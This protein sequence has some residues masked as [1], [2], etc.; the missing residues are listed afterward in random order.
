MT[1]IKSPNKKHLN[2]KVNCSVSFLAIVIFC[3]VF[4]SP[5]AFAGPAQ[6]QFTLWK[7]GSE[8]YKIREDA[9][10]GIFLTYEC[11]PVGTKFSDAKCEA[12][13]VLQTVSFAKIKKEELAGGKNPGAVLCKVALAAK[14]LILRNA[15]G[16][17]NSFCQLSDGSLVA[18]ASLQKWA[19]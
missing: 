2:C 9:E 16:D 3:S 6:K 15:R 12:A 13:K 4:S 18:T 8:I 14:V 19:K 1:F 5:S 17:E 10:Q 11:Y 7:D